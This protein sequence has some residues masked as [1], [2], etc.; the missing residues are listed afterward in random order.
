[1][2]DAF[3]LPL[4][5]DRYRATPATE[6][7]WSPEFQHGGPPTALLVHALERTAARDDALL[8]RITAEFLAPAPV[9]E[10]DVTTQVA[11]DGRNVQLLDAELLAGGRTVMRARAWRLRRA[12]LEGLDPVDDG[13]PPPL[14]DTTVSSPVGLDFG[15]ARAMEWR[16]AAG[17][18]DKPGPATVWTRLRTAVVAGEQPSPVQRVVA[19]ADSGS[20][21]SAV[22]EWARW[23][24]LNVDLTVHLRRPPEGEWV[25]LDSRTEVDSEGTG[26]AATTLWD[27]RGRIGVAAQSLLVMPR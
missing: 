17:A 7:P 27:R 2:A 26:L 23:T 5:R 19:A 18:T 10:L 8:T 6:G 12:V 16:V 4:G 1:M 22:L 15:Y 9:T 20:G 24:F 14:P 25:C 13:P 11:R 3:Y 21:V